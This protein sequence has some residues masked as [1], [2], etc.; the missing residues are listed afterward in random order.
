MIALYLFT[1]IF[2]ITFSLYNLKLTPLTV[3]DLI[4]F[5]LII[6]LMTLPLMHF[7]SMII[8]F[9]L[10][11]LI[12]LI[13]IK[14][15]NLYLSLILSIASILTYWVSDGISIN[16]CIWVLNLNLKDIS[17]NPI[18]YFLYHIL[19]FIVSYFVTIIIKHIVKRKTTLK[20]FSFKSTF[21]I[22]S[23]LC[24]LLLF[25]IFYLTI[26][27][28]KTNVLSKP[29]IM[30]IGFLFFSYFIIFGLIGYSFITNAK[31]EL[32]IGNKKRQLANLKEYTE[33]L[34]ILYNE[35]R[36][37]RH[38]H[39]NV[40]TSMV[41]YMDKND[42]QGLR[43]YFDNKIIPIGTSFEK[44]NFKLGLL[45][46]IKIPEIKGVV[47][48][49]LI[50][51]QHKEINVF[52]DIMEPIEDINIDIIDICKILGIILD[53]AIEASGDCENP[54]IKFAIINKKRSVIIIVINQCLENTPPIYKLFEKEFSTKGKNR[55][56]G[57]NNL[58]E[59]INS[60]NNVS[61]DTSI[62]DNEFIQNIEVLK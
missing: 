36:K 62:K 51:A 56:L 22:F 2:I 17:G 57:L 16:I 30:I 32:Q 31:K 6:F 60:Y 18:P 4:K 13:Y 5:I 8:I 29:K 48:S 14:T 28:I 52:I 50:T 37:F 54:I 39:I 38:D 42:M 1:I 33:T 9:I 25:I 53:N 46:N 61:L 19:I 44:K 49:K 59:I 26:L 7:T 12:I 21:S 10:I 43:R 47:S 27:L 34:E 15:K 40:L 45:Q 11:Y 58:K 41:G 3:H 55:G 23:I 20:S 24:L 35:T